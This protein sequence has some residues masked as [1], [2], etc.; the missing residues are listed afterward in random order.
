[1]PRKENICVIITGKG[2]D[3]A[4]GQIKEACQL[5]AGLVELRMDIIGGKAET[6]EELIGKA[7]ANKLRC[8]VTYRDKEEGGKFD[9]RGKEAL[10]LA[11]IAAGADYVDIEIRHEDM[12][13]SISKQAKKAGCRVIASWHDFGAR[14]NLP[15]MVEAIGKAKESSADIA[16]IAFLA[17][18]KD[19]KRIIAGLANAGKLAGMQVLVSP[20]G[21]DAAKVRAHALS[22]GSPFAYC[23][24]ERTAMAG[25]PTIRQLVE[26]MR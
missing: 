18:G 20:M 22:Q 2:S 7:H 23:T 3:S 15:G 10:A 8:I 6:A 9:G 5:G 19:G 17:S 14:P 4:E 16:K 24:L 26:F 11:A 1:M 25:V 12:I 13:K 21:A